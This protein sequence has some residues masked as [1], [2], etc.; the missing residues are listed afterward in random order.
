MPRA[1]PG[2]EGTSNVR[3]KG[4]VRAHASPI[5]DIVG[6]SVGT[7]VGGLSVSTNMCIKVEINTSIVSIVARALQRTQSM[8]M[9]DRGLGPNT[10]H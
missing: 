10:A 4:C 9:D 1:A 2:G 3:T 5:S 6:T 7:S 8:S